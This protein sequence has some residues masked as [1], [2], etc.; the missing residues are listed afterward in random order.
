MSA[1]STPRSPRFRAGTLIELLVAL[2][3]TV[4]M[5]ASM[6]AMTGTILSKWRV[7]SGS[8]SAQAEARRVLDQIQRD[9]E[10]AVIYAGGVGFAVDT[11]RGPLDTLLWEFPDMDRIKPLDASWDPDRDR[12]GWGGVWLRFFTGNAEVRAVSYKIVRRTPTGGA[13]PSQ[14]RYYLYRGQ[15]RGDRT[16][17]AGYDLL[18]PAYNPGSRPGGAVRVGDAAE[19]QR[20]RR[21]SLLANNVV[22]LGIRLYWR[23]LNA[24]VG[25]E[26]LL[27]FPVSES[28][29]HRAPAPSG[30]SWIPAN[31]VEALS[32]PEGAITNRVP[33]SAE[34]VVRVLTAE[35]A[36]R[37]ADFEN[38]LVS[39]DWWAIVDAHSKVFKRRV[40]LQSTMVWR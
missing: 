20:P 40:N 23:P 6:L 19:V 35:G 10:Q 16:F 4:A 31:Q 39:G 5:A 11:V 2:A 17:A 3:I 27:V 30:Q 14:A 15:V 8:V 26:E 24:A 1:F 38:G 32:L 18:A 36:E 13:D 34:V 29:R 9:L 22:D 21:D 12:F 37:L 25:R 7:A 28:Q 33:D